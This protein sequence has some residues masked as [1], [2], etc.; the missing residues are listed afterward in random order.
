MRKLTFLMATLAVVAIAS[1]ELAAQELLTDGTFES[2][3]TDNG[4]AGSSTTNTS[5]AWTL[6]SNQPDTT[7]AD[8]GNAET[9]RFQQAPF[10][11]NNGGGRVGIWFRS[12]EG[13][14]DQGDLPADAEFSQ[15]V[16]AGPGLYRLT[17]WEQHEENFTVLSTGK[18]EVAMD[19]LDSA[20]LVLG[21]VAFDLFSTAPT[22]LNNVTPSPPPFIFNE[23]FGEAPAGTSSITVRA[24]MEDGVNFIE[25]DPG[26]NFQTLSL[27]DFSLTQVPEPTSA[28]L[29]SLALLGF[30]IRRRR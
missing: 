23:L 18:A 28:L 14:Q 3:N 21:S 20:N 4:G 30:V 1:Q 27:D 6:T 10:A 25:I 2:N 16:A 26:Q 17:F 7:G 13:N 15:T 19:F 12:F 9:G 11:D 22:R 24:T 29:A 5:G 8:A